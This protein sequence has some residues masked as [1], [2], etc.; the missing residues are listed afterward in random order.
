MEEKEA[1]A[2]WEK[3]SKSIRSSCDE[4]DKSTEEIS[5]N[6]NRGT[7]HGHVTIIIMNIILSYD[8]IKQLFMLTNFSELYIYI[9]PEIKELKKLDI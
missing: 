9:Y 5:T 3:S 7:F 2:W 1:H 4:V 8:G 6:P